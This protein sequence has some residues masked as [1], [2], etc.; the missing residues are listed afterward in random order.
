MPSSSAAAADQEEMEDREPLLPSQS[1]SSPAAVVVVQSSPQRTSNS[2]S[3]WSDNTNNNHQQHNFVRVMERN[4]EYVRSQCEE[5]FA[6]RSSQSLFVPL[7]SGLI[8]FL[9]IINTISWH[10]N[11]SS[12]GAGS[13]STGGPAAASD[14]NPL[15]G[16]L[17]VLKD[18]D[19]DEGEG[20]DP[21]FEPH[22]PQLVQ[23]L[24]ISPGA[25]LIP[26]NWSVCCLLS[27]CVL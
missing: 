12:S 16:G 9:Y 2:S 23:L 4:L 17:D 24:T 20:E 25:L 27:C 19:E 5:V 26:Y 13:S 7:V 21:A 11:S 15:T 8:F 1:P 22:L 3:H 18:H 14:F 10:M 6:S